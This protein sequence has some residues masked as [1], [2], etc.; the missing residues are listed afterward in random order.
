MVT[1]AHIVYSPFFKKFWLSAS[2][3]VGVL[4]ISSGV[5]LA[6][7]GQH[8]GVAGVGAG[9][10]LISIGLAGY[11]AVRRSTK[12]ALDRG[13]PLS[14]KHARRSSPQPAAVV[15]RSALRPS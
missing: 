8:D 4:S 3:I 2:I 6:V 1:F 7:R 5:L 10:V 12:L 15:D 13:A 9:V 11:R 14:M